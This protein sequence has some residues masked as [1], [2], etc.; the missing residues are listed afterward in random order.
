MKKIRVIRLAWR[1][2]VGANPAG[3]GD[4]FR[5]T[6]RERQLLGLLVRKRCASWGDGSHWI[7]EGELDL[8]TDAP[9]SDSQDE[10]PDTTDD[11]AA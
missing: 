9:E 2:G 1:N 5:D 4:W 10:Q 6:H 3:A 11:P 8:E 7:E